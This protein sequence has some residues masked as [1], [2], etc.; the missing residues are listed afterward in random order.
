M[1]YIDL[2]ADLN[3]E[4]DGGHNGA[5]AVWSSDQSR[6]QGDETGDQDQKQEAY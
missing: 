1:I 4:D 3:L 5:A 2:P 6:I